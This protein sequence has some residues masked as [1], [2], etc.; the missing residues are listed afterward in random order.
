MRERDERLF[1]KKNLFSRDERDMG[2]GSMV[3][4]NLWSTGNI[5]YD[6]LRNV[7]YYTIMHVA[8]FLCN[9]IILII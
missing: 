2:A 8:V 6:V 5:A 3:D 7:Q 4:H 9:S 1:G